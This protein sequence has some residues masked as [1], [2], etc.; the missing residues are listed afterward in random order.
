LK[1]ARSVAFWPGNSSGSFD[2]AHVPCLAQG[3][4]LPLMEVAAPKALDLMPGLL[5][6]VYDEGEV[7]RRAAARER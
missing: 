3:A 1:E 4:L 6:G 7:R 2:G 5:H